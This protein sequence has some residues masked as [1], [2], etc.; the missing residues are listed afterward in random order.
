MNE[1]QM[2]DLLAAFTDAVLHDEAE[3]DRVLDRQVLSRDAASLVTLTRR[4]H[5]SIKPVE[6]SAAFTRRLKADL[7]GPESKTL[8]WRWR[9]LP[10]RVHI[11]AIL[12]AVFGFGG[13]G[14]IAVGRL[15]EGTRRHQDNK[16]TAS[17]IS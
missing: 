12:A 6:P 3:A 9:Q 1:Q 15:V 11:A 7:M 13:V 8:L 2:Q 5:T 16:E 17:T 10:A 14:L 4:L